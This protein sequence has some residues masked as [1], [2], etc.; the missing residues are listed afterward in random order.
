[1]LWVKPYVHSFTRDDGPM[2]VVVAPDSFG[3]TLS[4]AQAAAAIG[5]GWSAG[6]E[7]DEVVLRPLSDGG[8]G[9]LDVLATALVATRV[10]VR[11]PDPLGREVP[12]EILVCGETAYVE[13]AQ[14]CGLHLL[15]AD[16]RDPLVTTSYGLGVLLAAAVESGART[17]VIGL[18]GSATND[19]GAGMLTALGVVPRDAAGAVLPYGGLALAAAAAI[20]GTARLRGVDLVL[21]SDVDNPLLGP[22]GASAVFGPQKGASADDVARLDHALS[23]WAA[24]LQ[25]LPGCPPGV[26][27]EPGAGAAGGIGAALL[28]LGGRREMGIG[29]VRQIVGFDDVLAGAD[30]AVTGEGK[31]DAQS[32]RGK[33]VSGVAAAAAEHGLT[34]LVLAGQVALG[35]QEMAAAGVEAAYSMAEHAGSVAAAMADPAVQL[36]S[37]AQRVARLWSTGDQRVP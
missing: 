23:V 16:E 31:F 30:V 15:A 17:I 3:G 25:A 36:Q 35:R 32:V 33:V 2:R 34:C 6:A 4:A 20:D 27:L 1:M 19:G 13:S 24:L 10:P 18:G 21:A 12:A 26:A 9:F 28:A 14:A 29:L 7:R 11:V 5:A 22:S 8:T 37:L